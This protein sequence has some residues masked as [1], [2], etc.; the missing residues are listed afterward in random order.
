MQEG[1]PPLQFQ[2][3]LCALSRSLGGG[4]L[5]LKARAH[6]LR[7]SRGV[8]A[9]THPQHLLAARAPRALGRKE[10]GKAMWQVLLSVPSQGTMD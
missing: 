2:F 8:L 3:G 5:Q 4:E 7:Q 6:S 10:N 9:S 1:P